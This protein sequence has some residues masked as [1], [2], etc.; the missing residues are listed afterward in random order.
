MYFP[1]WIC[2]CHPRVAF[3][4]DI[5]CVYVRNMVATCCLV[6]L[7]SLDFREVA[8]TNSGN[9]IGM[10]IPEYELRFSLIEFQL[11]YSSQIANERA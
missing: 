11:M 1:N 2:L 6:V 4:E 10:I 8:L 3:C 5:G 9:F 7:A